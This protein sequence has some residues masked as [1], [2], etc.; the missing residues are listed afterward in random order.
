MSVTVAA[1]SNFDPLSHSRLAFVA[2]EASILVDGVTVV[3]RELLHIDEVARRFVVRSPRSNAAVRVDFGP[4]GLEAALVGPD[5][6]NLE[7]DLLI[8]GIR[9]LAIDAWAMC[10]RDAADACL[11]DAF[12]RAVIPDLCARDASMTP[13]VIAPGRYLLQ[14]STESG[15]CVVRFGPNAVGAC[16]QPA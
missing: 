12:G 9:A 2:A 5:R 3:R 11:L 10:V 16:V 8:G 13:M 7:I 6:A 4:S 15:P 14:A 1:W